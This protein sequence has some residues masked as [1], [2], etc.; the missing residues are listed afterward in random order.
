MWNSLSWGSP[1]SGDSWKWTQEPPCFAIIIGVR[2]R[3]HTKKA[4]LWTVPIGCEHTNMTKHFIHM[5]SRTVYNQT[6]LI[7]KGKWGLQ[8]P[9]WD[10]FYYYS[11]VIIST[12]VSQTTRVTIVY[13][14][15][16]SGA[17]QRKHQSSTSLSLVRGI[18]WSPVNS[19]RPVTRKMSSCKKDQLVWPPLN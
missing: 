7:L 14:T 10:L 9:T 12:M 8:M 15:I 13:S 3:S 5:W 2:L 1:L 18:H 6:I 16:Y 11:D 19:Q 4:A 17:D